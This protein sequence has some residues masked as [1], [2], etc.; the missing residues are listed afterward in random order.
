MLDVCLIGTSG[1]VPLKHRWLTAFHAVRIGKSGTA[2]HI[3][4]HVEWDMTLYLAETVDPPGGF[5]WVGRDS[6]RS[7]TAI[8]SAFRAALELALDPESFPGGKP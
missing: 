4:T 5:E 2:K 7:E 3:F 8:P 6:L 1:M